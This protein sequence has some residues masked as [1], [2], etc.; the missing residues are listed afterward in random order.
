[1]PR[2]RLLPS[3]ACGT[4][5]ATQLLGAIF[6]LAE[7]CYNVGLDPSIDKDADL[8]LTDIHLQVQGRWDE[9]LYPSIYGFPESLWTILSQIT[10]TANEQVR[11]STLEPRDPA[12]VSAL[13]LHIQDLEGTIW[14]WTSQQIIG[15]PRPDPTPSTTGPGSRSQPSTESVAQALHQ[16][17]ILC[18]YRKIYNVSP[19]ILRDTVGRALDHLGRCME[20][21]DNPDL[22]ICIAWAA[23]TAAQEASLPSHQEEAARILG[24]IGS[25]G[26]SLGD[27]PA[28][29]SA[30][31]IQKESGLAAGGLAF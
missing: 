26:I 8:G 20:S 1:M 29:Q 9:S 14:G 18:F 6:C 31:L 22:T 28:K 11:V 13:Q 21:I 30:S 10:A 17:L 27:P 12:L 23:L 25:R 24:S 15:P 16:S 3:T 4:A 2:S 19:M 5:H 7:E